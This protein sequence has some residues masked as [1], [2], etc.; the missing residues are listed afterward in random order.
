[1]GPLCS[2]LN[3][4]II[5]VIQYTEILLEVCLLFSTVAMNCAFIFKHISNPAV[6]LD[7]DLDT[8]SISMAPVH[9]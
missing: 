6:I 7:Y 5:T 1:M 3:L 2:R 8:K 4:T 9:K